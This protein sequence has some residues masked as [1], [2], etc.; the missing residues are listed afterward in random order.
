MN[1]FSGAR[2]VIVEVDGTR[3]GK[4][5][6]ELELGVN[7]RLCG[8]AGHV[9]SQGFIN[10]FAFRFVDITTIEK[11]ESPK[12]LGRRRGRKLPKDYDE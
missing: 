12:Y 9:V 1:Y 5:S 7:E 2:S 4:W 3:A 8:F 11:A 10:C 6:Q